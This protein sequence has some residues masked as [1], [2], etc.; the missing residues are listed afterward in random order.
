MERTPVFDD[1]SIYGKVITAKVSVNFPNNELF[2]VNDKIIV[3]MCDTA[4]D[5]NPI[6]ND[7]NG[8]TSYQVENNEPRVG[9]SVNLYPKLGE[10]MRNPIL[11]VT[12]IRDGKIFA[13]SSPQVLFNAKQKQYNIIVKRVK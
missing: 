9:F 8:Y 12:V 3:R 1:I 11:N 7:K 10:K 5:N 2:Q 4:P 13:Q 6:I